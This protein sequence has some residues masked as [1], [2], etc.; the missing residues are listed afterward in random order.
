MQHEA[1]SHVQA[2]ITNTAAEFESQL[3]ADIHK[4]QEDLNAVP[5]RWR[6]YSRNLASLSAEYTSFWQDPSFIEMAER[7]QAEG[8]RQFFTFED[9]AESWNQSP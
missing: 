3:E 6:R 8:G 1:Q 7:I 4:A 5:L 9:Q 2:D